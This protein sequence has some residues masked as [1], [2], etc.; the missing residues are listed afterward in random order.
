V[1]ATELMREHPAL[2][3]RYGALLAFPYEF[4]STSPLTPNSLS[5]ER[6][7][8]E[9]TLPAFDPSAEYVHPDSRVHIRLTIRP[10]RAERTR[11]PSVSVGLQL[12]EEQEHGEPAPPQTSD[13]EEEEEDDDTGPRKAGRRTVKLV[14]TKLPFSPKKNRS[15]KVAA[16]PEEDDDDEEEDDDDEGEEESEYEGKKKKKRQSPTRRSTRT[17]KPT[18]AN[19]DQVEDSDAY[20][21]E[22]SG[23]DASDALNLRSTPPRKGKGTKADKSKKKRTPT[24]ARPAYG[25]IRDVAD[26]GAYDSDPETAAL[27]AHR[28]ECERCKRAPAHVELAR[29]AKRAKG[30]KKKGGRKRKDPDEESSDE[31]A[32]VEALGG[33]VRW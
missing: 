22:D 13:G 8:R 14:Q 1:L 10:H 23:S 26:D 4:R 19:A 7:V 28:A 33:W 15:R 2:V 31:E 11:A 29:L 12:A 5:A 32:A 21:D 24:S 6:K 18:R 9:G 25:S 16:A 17:R 27:R 20:A 30:K 3:T